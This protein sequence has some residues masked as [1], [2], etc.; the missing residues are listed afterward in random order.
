MNCYQLPIELLVEIKCSTPIRI[1]DDYGRD[2]NDGGDDDDGNDDKDDS[3]DDNDDV[4][5]EIER[6]VNSS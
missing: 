6:N 5:K 3:D 1:G 2:D 4:D